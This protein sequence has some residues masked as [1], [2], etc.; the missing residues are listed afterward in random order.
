MTDKPIDVIDLLARIRRTSLGE[1]NHQFT[2]APL[3]FAALQRE[4]EGMSAAERRAAGEVAV[5][6]QLGGDARTLAEHAFEL[7]DLQRSIDLLTVAV[8]YDYPGASRRRD[9]IQAMFATVDSTAPTPRTIIDA[10]R[11]VPVQLPLHNPV[12]VGREDLLA[13]LDE[14]TERPGL[15]TVSGAA[16]VGKT[17][18]VLRWAHQAQHRFPGGVLFTN[19][20]GFCDGRA[21]QHTIVAA[22]FLVGLGEPFDGIPAS[23]PSA[24]RLRSLLSG[25]KVLVILDN[26]RDIEQVRELLPVL[27]ECVVVVTSRSSLSGV[28]VRE[29]PVQLS[30]PPLSP[31]SSARLV[32]EHIGRRARVEHE[33]LT[34]LVKPFGGIPLA[35]R[36]L[37][38]HVVDH[39]AVRFADLLNDFSRKRRVL[40][41]GLGSDTARCGLRAM[42]AQSVRV[43][44]EDA[45][46]L[47]RLL[48]AHPGPD[49]GV[50][51]TTA[52]SGLP[53]A[54]AQHALDVM[55]GLHLLERPRSQRYGFHRLVHEYA[56]DLIDHT[57]ERFEAEQRLFSFY[58]CSV[59]AAAQLLFFAPTRARVTIVD[60]AGLDFTGEASARAWC[61]SERQNIHALVRLGAQSG[62]H[63]HAAALSQLIGQVLLRY[64]FVDEA[65]ALMQF[66]LAAAASAGAVHEAGV[67]HT[68]ALAHLLRQEFALAQQH[69]HMAHA[70]FADTADDIGLAMCLETGARI[71]LA[72][73]N[74][75]TAI[76]SHERALSLIRSKGQASMEAAFLCNAGQAY[77]AAGAFDQAEIYYREA[78]SLGSRSGDIARCGRALLLLGSLVFDQGRMDEAE[79]FLHVA[80][81]QLSKI[82]DLGA[83]GRTMDLLS[84]IEFDRA[85][86]FEA[87]QY[88]RQAVKLCRRASDRSEEAEAL[89]T[90][91]RIL[92]LTAR[93][94]G[95]AEAWEH[96]KAIYDDLEPSQAASLADALHD[97]G[98]RLR[99]ANEVTMTTPRGEVAPRHPRRELGAS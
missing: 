57:T 53:S 98:S 28:A 47:F 11:P 45:R 42:F 6:A 51:M 60:D 38:Q 95:A 56:G 49:F 9:E 36:V 69:L 70:Q 48:G 93:Y 12:F 83:V 40:D 59:Y 27:S 20:R 17:E 29:S 23:G 32:T 75:L 66:G 46:R 13:K 65:L 10:S 91:G 89:I 94:D 15:V 90:L 71:M 25:R 62:H 84:Q 35:L 80:L 82:H 37:V 68:I 58:I 43:L 63:E 1:E 73:G 99:A 97:L 52:L 50:E 5:R 92:A 4:V 61:I 26:A 81:S 85:Q 44:D 54:Q 16:G 64:G 30:V 86:I 72:T 77:N 87:T 22:Q 24:A 31:E 14:I 41:L 79:M 33:V 39:P 7:G 8:A 67:R 96:A 21:L 88:A 78:L 3:D 74:V 76:D 34:R 19:L 2:T 18:L 55:A